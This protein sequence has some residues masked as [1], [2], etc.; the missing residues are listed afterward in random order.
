[1]YIIFAILSAAIL[2]MKFSIHKEYILPIWFL[3]SG[4]IS[5]SWG[6]N[7]IKTGDPKDN[8]VGMETI[9]MLVTMFGVAAAIAAIGSG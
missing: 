9:N 6:L 1:M 2:L 8:T 4:I 7:R 3:F 5:I